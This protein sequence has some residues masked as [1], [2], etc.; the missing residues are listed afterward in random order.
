MATLPRT[1]DKMKYILEEHRYE[2][3]Q[4]HVEKELGYQLDLEFNNVARELRYI[5]KR[6]ISWMYAR[7]KQDYWSKRITEYKIAK[8]EEGREAIYEA[9]MSLVEY[10]VSSMGYRMGDYTGYDI[11]TNNQVETNKIRGKIE[12]SSQALDN[13][14]GSGLFFKGSYGYSWKKLVDDNYRSDY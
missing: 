10:G 12:L 2:L 13:I 5:S 8:T 7:V 1:D 3:L 9:M 14:I 6:L 4:D 11:E